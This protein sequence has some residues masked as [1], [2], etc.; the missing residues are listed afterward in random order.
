M[1][2]FILNLAPALLAALFLAPA[3]SF[4]ST[5]YVSISTGSDSNTSTQAQSKSTPWAHL[6]G[7]P[8]ATGTAAGSYSAVAGDVFILMG[9]DVWYNTPGTSNF[10]LQL[11]NGGSSGNP[12]TITVDK[13]W[14]NTTNCPSG[15]NRPVFDGHTSASSSTPTQ[16]GGTTS[17]CISSYGNYFV[18]FT[19][20][21]ITL[22]SIELRNLYY[23]ND[24]ENTCYGGNGLFHVSSADYIT[25][26]NSYEHDWSMGTYA[27]GSV[28]DAD[29]F[30]LIDGSPT[31]P[32]CLLTYNVA[33]NCASTTGSGTQP[34]GAL[35][36][37]NV[38]YSI[39]KCM[40]NAYKPT[41][42]G[43]FGWNEITMI[44]DSPDPTLHPNCIE[45]INA[46]GNG[47]IYLIHDNVVHDNYVCEGL[48]VGNPGETDYVWNNLWYN[49]TSS[50]ANGPQ[51]PQSETPVAMYFFNNTVVDWMGG[52]IRDAGHGYS[53]SGAFYSVNNFC[54]N[55][56]GIISSS[57]NPTASTLLTIPNLGITDS[58]AA[59][60]GYTNAQNFVYSPASATSP[61]VGI[62]LNPTSSSW[63]WPA[64]ASINDTTDACIQQTTITGVVQ[65]V[66]PVR[67]AQTR[68]ATAAWDVGAYQFPSATTGTPAP[69]TGL[70]GVGN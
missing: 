37:V 27:A 9:C 34:G 11:S 21:Y 36:F 64:A 15:W 5:Y 7:M 46:I 35:S 17:G 67:T 13:T 41:Y 12:V 24:A 48:Q 47:G 38:T 32:H 53:W 49:N 59:T 69:P 54:I 62:G 20:S 66:C 2:R 68:P 18:H 3:I 16:I 29:E 61:T 43:E 19:A 8:T 40:S 51:V 60:A 56:S 45:S 33:N 31:C 25:V 55:S 39:F 10:P 6:P 50:G 1:K 30:V 70:T 57:A 52:C 58:A 44:G 23:A 26:S 42:A 14:Y 63:F 4:A 28:S 22:D 65:S